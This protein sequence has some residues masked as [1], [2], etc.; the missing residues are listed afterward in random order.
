MLHRAVQLGRLSTAVR[1]FLG[2]SD[3]AGVCHRVEAGRIEYSIETEDG[4]VLL[5]RIRRLLH[6]LRRAHGSIQTLIVDTVLSR[7]TRW[8]AV[9]MKVL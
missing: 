2:T 3:G 6:V 8:I 7:I 5:G 1:H 9:S 4:A